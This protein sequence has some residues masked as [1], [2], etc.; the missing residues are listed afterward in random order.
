MKVVRG[1]VDWWRRRV[2]RCVNMGHLPSVDMGCN[3][4]AEVLSDNAIGVRI[5]LTHLRRL[6]TQL[7]AIALKGSARGPD[8]DRL[9]RV[10]D[11]N[12]DKRLRV[13]SE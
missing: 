1:E 6:H 7:R 13:S 11:K 8:W 2:L 3:L 5:T 10:V 12:H 4:Q 9:F